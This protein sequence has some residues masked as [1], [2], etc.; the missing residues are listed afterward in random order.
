MLRFAVVV[1][2][3]VNLESVEAVFVDA[4]ILGVGFSIEPVD[5]A[6]D[7]IFEFNGVVDLAVKDVGIIK[8]F[9]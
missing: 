6:T 8:Y 5:V 4:P 9:K 2:Q 1:F 7:K 3:S